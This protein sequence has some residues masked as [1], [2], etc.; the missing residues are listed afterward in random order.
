MSRATMPIIASLNTGTIATTAVPRLSYCSRRMIVVCLGVSN[1]RISCLGLQ[2]GM[3]G[4]AF[5]HRA[6]AR[7][8]VVPMKGA[9][10]KRLGG[11]RSSRSKSIRCRSIS[12]EHPHLAVELP[13]VSLHYSPR[14]PRIFA[15]LTCIHEVRACT[16]GWR[17]TRRKAL[18]VSTS[19]SNVLY[20]FFSGGSR[21]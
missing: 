19:W 8:V 9:I 15:L 16:E 10:R 21:E 4:D 18:P 12:P 13:T 17:P 1:L 20:C 5:Q 6:E 11:L 3:D 14:T 7:V 2:L